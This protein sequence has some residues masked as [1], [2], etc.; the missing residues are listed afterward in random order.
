MIERTDTQRAIYNAWPRIYR[1]I[2]GF[3]YFLLN[4]LKDTVK[5]A[6]QMIRS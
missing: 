5:R 1:I 2:N 4:L 6:I 3:F